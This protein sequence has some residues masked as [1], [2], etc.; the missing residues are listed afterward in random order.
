MGVLT[1]IEL[2]NL[3]QHNT[4]AAYIPHTSLCPMFHAYLITNICLN[5]KELWHKVSELDLQS[6]DQA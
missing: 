1:T 5:A 6:V 2:P 3:K 4:A